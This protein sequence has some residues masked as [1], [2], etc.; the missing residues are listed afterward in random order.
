M[1]RFVAA[2]ILVLGASFAGT[3]HAQ[4]IRCQSR[5]FQYQFCPSN[6]EVI[7]ASL[8]FQD[9]QA[10]CIRGRTWGWN[11]GGVWV[12]NGCS[13]RFRVE[14]FRPLPPPLPPGGDRLTCASRDFR[15]E[16]CAVPQ[17][18]F[19]VEL[20]RQTSRSSCQLGRTW[21]W[22]DDGVWVSGG[23]AGEFRV[24]TQ[25]A[26]SPPLRPGQVSCASR[27]F[28]YT[29]CETGPI[30]GAQ[31]MVQRSQAPCL[32]GNSWGTTPTGIWVDHG[33]SATFRITPRW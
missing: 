30:V 22:R 14:T 5:N 4:E 33:C 10:A 28:R 21:G 32:R 12:S 24:Q 3:A 16:F 6:G 7:D 27:G 26:P 18:V 20:V 29:F 13:G 2:A 11:N 9:S 25:F 19:N 31:M 23:C 17:R 15:H 8:V 1:K